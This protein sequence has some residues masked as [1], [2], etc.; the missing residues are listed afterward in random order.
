MLASSSSYRQHFLWLGL[1]F[2]HAPFIHQST[3]WKKIWVELESQEMG[4]DPHLSHHW[5][6]DVFQVWRLPLWGWRHH[7]SKQSV[8]LKTAPSLPY[9]LLTV[10]SSIDLLAEVFT[11]DLVKDIV[12]YIP[13]VLSLIRRCQQVNQICFGFAYIKLWDGWESNLQTLLCKVDF[14]TL[15]IPFVELLEVPQQVKVM[16]TWFCHLACPARSWGPKNMGSRELRWN[17]RIDPQGHQVIQSKVNI[18]K[19]KTK[20]KPKLLLSNMSCFLIVY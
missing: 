4:Q 3:W 8:F 19:K 6:S 1:I 16:R 17:Q 15:K 18:V 12:H 14:Q 10:S 2:Q 11:L 13:D 5:S 7:L 20:K 9:P